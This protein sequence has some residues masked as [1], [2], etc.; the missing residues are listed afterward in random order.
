VLQAFFLR[1]EDGAGIGL[2]HGVPVPIIKTQ[3]RKRSSRFERNSFKNNSMNRNPCFFGRNDQNPIKK[4]RPNAFRP[5][6]QT[7]ALSVTLF[8]SVLVVL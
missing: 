5:I 6:C 8:I 1:V 2:V 3:S 7:S 4:L